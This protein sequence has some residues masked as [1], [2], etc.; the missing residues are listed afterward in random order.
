MGG[1]THVRSLT[2]LV[3]R[4]HRQSWGVL[5]TRPGGASKAPGGRRRLLDLPTRARECRIPQFVQG[6]PLGIS[7]RASGVPS[8]HHGVCPK[9]RISPCAPGEPGARPPVPRPEPAGRRPG[10]RR[11][12]LPP[13]RTWRL[14]LTRAFGRRVASS[15][16]GHAAGRD[17]GDGGVLAP[18]RVPSRVRVRVGRAAGPD[19]N[20]SSSHERM[21]RIKQNGIL[22]QL[23]RDSWLA[24]TEGLL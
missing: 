3:F 15:R 20:G 11:A 9:D 4:H 1:L 14:W 22:G 8:Q 12:L 18:R 2:D 17:E 21:A 13:G 19:V 24:F 6:L 7:P 5:P 23:L 16:E 10:G